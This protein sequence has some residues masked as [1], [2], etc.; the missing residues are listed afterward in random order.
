M[1]SVREQFPIFG[2]LV[3]G[4]RLV[5]LDSAATTQKPQPVLKALS[6]HYRLHNAN[7]HRATHALGRQATRAYEA[8]RDELAQ[9]VYA[10]ERE[11]LIITR[12]ATDGLNLIANGYL[13]P[14]LLPGDEL[15]ITALEHHANLLPWQRLAHKHGAQLKV[16][17]LDG[18][19]NLDLAAYARLLGPQTRLVAMAHVSNVLGTVLPVA[20]MVQLAHE[21]GAVTVVDGTQAAAHLAIDVQALGCDFYVLSGHKMYGPTGV[22]ALYGRLE[23]LEAIE[24][25]MLGGEMVAEVDYHSVRFAE[26]P[27]RLEAGTPPI[28][29]AVAMGAAAMF[30]TGLDRQRLREHEADLLEQLRTTL[31][32]IDGV[33]LIGSPESQVALQS[34]TVAGWHP[35]DLARALDLRGIAVRAGHHCAQPLVKALGL[36]GTVRASLGVYSGSD[37]IA[38][39]GQALRELLADSDQPPQ[40]QGRVQLPA[41]P[42]A[43]R[44]QALLKLGRE[45]PRWLAAEQAAATAVMGCESKT[46]LRLW[47]EG[48]AV[49]A[50][51]DSDSALIRGVIAL[52]VAQ[53]N[54][55]PPG[56]MRDFDY[57]DY[58]DREGLWRELSPSRGNGLRA[59]I[60][61]LR[62]L[63]GERDRVI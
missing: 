55:L 38:A 58:L 42:W 50:A 43:Q 57:D 25:A 60:N 26:L 15:V 62:H 37:C 5:Y 22:G 29:E 33:T 34:F 16:A 23:L 6:D 19:G 54:G 8:A 24:P 17:P 59:I 53:V 31:A 30:I 27:Y 14:R 9:F 13:A 44:Y 51:G 52:L 47:Q 49:Y 28:A 56:Q 10:P 1:L 11:S 39:L 7:I 41:G 48:E 63:A 4:Q 18:D 2:Q 45:Q 3:E 40:Q 12:G 35:H 46:W 20:E 61:A 21:V 36:A 32:A